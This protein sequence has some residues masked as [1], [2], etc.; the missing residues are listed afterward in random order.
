MIVQTIPHLKSRGMHPPIPPLSTP[1][2]WTDYVVVKLLFVITQSCHSRT[3]HEVL[4]SVCQY[5]YLQCTCITG[6]TKVAVIV[7]DFANMSGNHNEKRMEV[8][9]EKQPKTFESAGLVFTCGK[10][11][12]GLWV[13][14]GDLR[15]LEEFLYLASFEPEEMRIPSRSKKMA[16]N[17]LFLRN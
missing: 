11:D 17:F 4:I 7:H 3:R 8:F 16:G 14:Q 2:M 1:L 9:R 15:E 13:R 6:K 10:L 12:K 5:H